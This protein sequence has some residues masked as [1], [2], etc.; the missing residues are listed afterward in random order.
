MQLGLAI[1]FYKGAIGSIRGGLAN[2][3]VLVS[4]GTLAIYLYSVF[5]LF[6]HQSMGHDGASHVYFEASVMVIG[7]VSLG[8]FLEERTK[9]QSLNSLGLLLQLTPKQVSVQREN[10][11]E[12]IPLDQVKIGDILRANQ[13]ERIAADGV[14]EQGSGW[15]R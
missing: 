13:G 12:T 7:F 6:Y 8:K 15:L 11:W 3:D 4:T 10:R 9:K 1:P 2:M 14:V 5:M